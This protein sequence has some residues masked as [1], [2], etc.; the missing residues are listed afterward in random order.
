MDRIGV[1]H[2]HLAKQRVAPGGLVPVPEPSSL[3]EI[4]LLLQEHDGVISRLFELLD[5]LEIRVAP[6]M[7]PS[8]GA[9]G[10]VGGETAVGS[11][12][13]CTELGA[14]MRTSIDRTCY[15]ISRLEDIVSRIQL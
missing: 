10:S 9:S 15:A 14:R 12:L 8:P 2:N 4:P 11:P 1:S 3:P 13:Q 5:A 6:V 7:S